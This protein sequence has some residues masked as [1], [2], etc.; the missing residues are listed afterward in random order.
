M[1]I[2]VFGGSFDPVHLGHVKIAKTTAKKFAIDKVL[3]VPSKISHQK[4]LGA[5]TEDRVAMLET[6]LAEWPQAEICKYEIEKEDN[7]P[8]YSIYTLQHLK[9]LYPKDEIYFLMGADQFKTF[10][11]WK[12]NSEILKI[13]QVI[14]YKRNHVAIKILLKKYP[15]LYIDDHL[16]NMSSTMIKQDFLDS[17]NLHHDVY[18]YIL[19]HGLYLENWLKPLMFEKRYLHT[20]RVAKYMST[21]L[22]KHHP[23]LERQGWIAGLYHDIAKNFDSQKLLEIAKLLKIEKFPIQVVHGPVGAWFLRQ[24][25]LKDKLVL[26][27]ITKHTMP[28]DFDSEEPLT[29]LDKLIYC[30]DK[31]EPARTNGEIDRIDH[32]RKLLDKNLDECFKTLYASLQIREKD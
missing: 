5:S 15:V 12:S 30:C 26:T 10:E 7:E 24:H 4:N 1:K 17:K 18:L 19:N 20:M 28:F 3:F 32:Y 13:C 21:Y 22:R 14:V 25:G 8:S 9:K 6:A 2:L 11:T 27:A 23:Q 31:L 29:I 16:I